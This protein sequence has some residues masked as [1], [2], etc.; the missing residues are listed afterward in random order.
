MSQAGL[1][2]YQ[3]IKLKLLLLGAIQCPKDER[4]FQ[5]ELEV[6]IQRARDKKRKKDKKVVGY[7]YCF[8]VK[9]D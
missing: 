1:L 3:N 4:L 8:P 9:F 2:R 5:Y 7:N 6:R